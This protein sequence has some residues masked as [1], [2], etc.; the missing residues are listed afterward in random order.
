VVLYKSY[1]ARGSWGENFITK[2]VD[3]FMGPNE[4]NCPAKVLDYLDQHAPLDPTSKHDEYAR[5]WRARCR[6]NLDKRANAEKPY[7]GCTI[8]LAKP[9][10]FSNGAELDTFEYRNKRLYNGGLRY[11]VDFRKYEYV[12]L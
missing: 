7:E 3:E 12:V 1:K 4:S 8:L 10:R 9:L 6:K 11:S 2:A 5:D